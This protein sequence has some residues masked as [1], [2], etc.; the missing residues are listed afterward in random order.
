MDLTKNKYIYH[1]LYHIK[2]KKKTF[3]IKTLFKTIIEH[4]KVLKEGI[5][6]LYTCPVRSIDQR[7]EELLFC[8]LLGGFVGLP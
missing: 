4:L 2:K 3:S 7:N 8:Q 6:L 1:L 5:L